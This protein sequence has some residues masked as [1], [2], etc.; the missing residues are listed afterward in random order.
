MLF[1]F[2][3][4]SCSFTIFFLFSALV[5]MV[6]DE[7]PEVEGCVICVGVCGGGRGVSNGVAWELLLSFSIFLLFASLANFKLAKFFFAPFLRFGMLKNVCKIA[8][9]GCRTQK[10]T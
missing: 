7:T 2:T 6:G 3:L 9:G 10:H 4:F 1:L 5:R 8:A